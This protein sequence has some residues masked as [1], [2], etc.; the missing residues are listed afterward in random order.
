MANG[1]GWQTSDLRLGAYL[2]TIGFKITE[3]KKEARNV[4]FTFEDQ[5]KRKMEIAKFYN[6]EARVEPLGFMASMGEM[7]DMITMAERGASIG[8]GG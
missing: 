2:R 7:R 4:M 5:D 8:S 6:K 1:T 3:V